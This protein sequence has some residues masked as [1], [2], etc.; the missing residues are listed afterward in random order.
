MANCYHIAAL[1]AVTW[2]TPY[3]IS[4][5]TRATDQGHFAIKFDRHQSG[6]AL[7]YSATTCTDASTPVSLWPLVTSLMVMV[8][9]PAASALTE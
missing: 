4:H 2:A 6:L 7:R 8:C 3:R 9:G 1:S 5:L